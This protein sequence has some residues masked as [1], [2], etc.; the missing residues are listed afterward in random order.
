MIDLRLKNISKKIIKVIAIGTLLIVIC[1][2]FTII[3]NNIPN[4][5]VIEA[6]S[7]QEVI[8]NAAQFIT[9]ENIIEGSRFILK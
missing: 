4:T 6:M 3:L 5:S 1:I 2:G 8:K 7:N 9:Q